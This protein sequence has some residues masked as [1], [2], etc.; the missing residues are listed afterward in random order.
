MPTTKY[1]GFELSP[2][3]YQLRDTKKWTARV[4]ITKHYDS[5]GETLEKQVAANKTFKKK[6]DAERYALEFGKEIIDGKHVNLSL[7][8]LL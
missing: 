8:D 5:R 7:D 3:P 1:K 4:T 2:S 6:E